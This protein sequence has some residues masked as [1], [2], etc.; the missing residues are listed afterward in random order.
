[1]QFAGGGKATIITS[2]PQRTDEAPGG[3]VM[4]PLSGSGGGDASWRQSYWVWPL[5]PPGQLELVCEWPAG[6]IPLTRHQL[7]AQL[8]LLAAPRTQLLF[9]DA[10]TEPDAT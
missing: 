4:W 1:L 2:P 9:T 7:D 5:L 10:G 3:P 8:V 6:Q